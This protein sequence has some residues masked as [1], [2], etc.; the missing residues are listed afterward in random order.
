MSFAVTDPRFDPLPAPEQPP[1]DGGE[2]QDDRPRGRGCFFWGCLTLVVLFLVL[3]IGVPLAAYFTLKH[4][5]NKFTAD[6]PLNIVAVELPEE[7]M[8]ALEA[9]FEAFDAS[10][11]KG[12]PQNLEVTAKEINAM[13]SQDDQL[14][15]HVLV[16]IA[17]GKVGGDVSF[18]AN[19]LPGGAGRHFNAAVDF[20]VSMVGGVLVVTLADSKVNGLS[21]PQTF[22]DNFAGQNFAEGFYK[23]PENAEVLRK[24]ESLE[25]VGDKIILRAR[26]Q[27]AEE[28]GL[29]GAPEIEA[30]EI[31]TIEEAEVPVAN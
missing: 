9:R 20:D 31:E 10:I 6:A 7:E 28:P 2:F 27:P 12:E 24:F 1:V 5:V 18:P 21:L 13:I 15:G 8:K 4:Y 29:P 11:E 16:R 23:D 26:K 17:D 3:L 22:I 14:K 19:N 25:I 30:P